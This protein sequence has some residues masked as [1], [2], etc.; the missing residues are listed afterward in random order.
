MFLFDDKDLSD[1]H[2]LTM[3]ALETTLSKD[4]SSRHAS[5]FKVRN[6]RRF[7][8]VIFPHQ[9]STISPSWDLIIQLSEDFLVCI[10][11]DNIHKLD[12]RVFNIE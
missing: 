5:C 7:L 4:D 11:I 10:P 3:I 2:F 6:V 8:E 9:T 1:L 12:I